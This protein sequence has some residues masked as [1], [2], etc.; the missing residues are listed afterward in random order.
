MF[1]LTAADLEGDILGC[2]DGPASFNAVATRNGASVVSCDPLYQYGREEIRGRID[3]TYLEMLEQTRQNVDAFVWSE[4][5]TPDD[6][7]RARMDA[8]CTFLNDYEVGRAE[9]RYVTDELPS[10]AFDDRTFDLALCSHFLFLY[11]D[12][13]SEDFHV[14]AI[15]DLS[16]VAQ[17]VRIF[18]LVALGGMPSHHLDAVRNRLWDAGLDVTME[19]VPYEFVRGAN[20]LMRVRRSAG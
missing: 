8:M 4:F 12:Q 14:R 10:L 18:P 19:S 9:G 20:V 2:A 6:L 13:L 7:G 16:R 17:E 1:A 5:A 15:V 3:A 11:S